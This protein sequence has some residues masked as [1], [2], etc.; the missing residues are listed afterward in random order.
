[1]VFDPASGALGAPVVEL[2]VAP[3][4]DADSLLVPAGVPF[5]TWG[6]PQPASKGTN[7]NQR[8][9]RADAPRSDPPRSGSR[10]S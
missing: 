9:H 2:A 3:I 8:G 6:P 7:A 4:A 1:M 5:G 10:S